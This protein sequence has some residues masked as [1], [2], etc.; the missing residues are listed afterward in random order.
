MLRQQNVNHKHDCSISHEDVTTR[1]QH[2]RIMGKMIANVHVLRESA[3]IDLYMITHNSH[4]ERTVITAKWLQMHILGNCDY[5]LYLCLRGRK[6][7]QTEK[8]E[9]DLYGVNV[10][11]IRRAFWMYRVLRWSIAVAENKVP[12]SAFSEL[13]KAPS[14]KPWQGHNT[15]LYASSIAT[16]SAFQIL[17]SR[18]VQ[19]NF[20]SILF[21]LE[22]L[23][24]VGGE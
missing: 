4:K 18:F 21:I 24:V 19:F 20:P 6:K 7:K 10:P 16:M 14:C 13:L 22:L 15:A 11:Q 12:T 2:E 3:I 17:P 23:C 8:K 1:I 5:R 9:L